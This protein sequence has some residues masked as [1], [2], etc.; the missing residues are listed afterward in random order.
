MINHAILV[1][2]EKHN[3]DSYQIHYQCLNRNRKLNDSYVN[4]FKGFELQI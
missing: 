4:T 3:L 1:R 2:K